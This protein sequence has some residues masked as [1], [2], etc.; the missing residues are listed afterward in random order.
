MLLRYSLQLRIWYVAT[1][2]G[3]VVVPMEFLI[4][5]RYVVMELALLRYSVK[6]R[7][8]PIVADTEVVE[9]NTQ[10]VVYVAAVEARKT[11]RL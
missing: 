1:R 9:E 4:D 2:S 11:G 10:L 8:E 3:K 7:I 5:E 6:E